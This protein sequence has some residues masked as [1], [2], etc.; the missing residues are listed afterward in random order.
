MKDPIH[1][2]IKE[3]RNWFA[4]FQVEIPVPHA[5]QNGYDH[6]DDDKNLFLYRKPNGIHLV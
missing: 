2:A 1:E 4:K 6:A 3:N 5:P